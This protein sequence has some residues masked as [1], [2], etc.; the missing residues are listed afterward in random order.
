VIQAQEHPIENSA[1]Q[2]AELI[3][4]KYSRVTIEF[5]G[6]AQSSCTAFEI[7]DR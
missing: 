2:R 7:G 5:L 1:T 4:E 6:G 3:P